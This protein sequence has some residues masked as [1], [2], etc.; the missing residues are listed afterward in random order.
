MKVSVKRVGS[1]LALP[2]PDD[3]AASLGLRHGAEGEIQGP[4]ADGSLRLV[5]VVGPSGGEPVLPSPDD[6]V[7]AVAARPAEPEPDPARLAEEIDRTIRRHGS[8][9]REVDR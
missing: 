5:P 8:S 7:R 2:V 4:A 9:L 1:G 6:V 3:L